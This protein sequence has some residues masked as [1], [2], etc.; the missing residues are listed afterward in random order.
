M[1]TAATTTIESLLRQIRCRGCNK[2]LAE[3]SGANVNTMTIRIK[4]PR[5]GMM[6]T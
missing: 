6:Y 2:L 3:V 1:I 4:C 5:C